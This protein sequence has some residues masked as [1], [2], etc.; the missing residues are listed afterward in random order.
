VWSGQKI[1]L[2]V[3]WA[4]I[5]EKHMTHKKKLSLNGKADIDI[6]IREGDVSNI[7]WLYV[8]LFLICRTQKK[9]LRSASSSLLTNIVWCVP[10]KIRNVNVVKIALLYISADFEDRTQENVR[11][12]WV[13]IMN[14]VSDRYTKSERISYEWGVFK[15]EKSI[16][17]I[18]SWC[19][20]VAI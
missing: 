16:H 13:N 15:I 10:R 14:S 3:F 4:G 5:L 6:V 7:P 8:V 18:Y 1:Y 19:S 12:E 20:K 17:F 11:K 2:I 9:C